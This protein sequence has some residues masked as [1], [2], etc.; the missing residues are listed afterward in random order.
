MIE[1]HEVGCPCNLGGTSVLF[2]PIEVA[3]YVASFLQVY[4]TGAARDL[5]SIPESGRS[6]GG[7]QATLSVFLPGE[8]HGQKSLTGYSP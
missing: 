5:G 1:K 7:G 2:I 3:V 8:F 6:P 4:S